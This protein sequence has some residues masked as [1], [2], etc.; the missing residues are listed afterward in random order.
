MQGFSCIWVIFFEQSEK[1][2]FARIVIWNR[3]LQAAGKKKQ[4][5]FGVRLDAALARHFVFPMGHVHCRPR[6][7]HGVLFVC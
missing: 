2:L 4:M 7:N 3:I 6:R 1:E 5:I